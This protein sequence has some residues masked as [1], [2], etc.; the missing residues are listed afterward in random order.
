MKCDMKCSECDMKCI[1]CDL[2]ACKYIE[3]DGVGAAVC[4][5]HYG[6]VGLEENTLLWAGI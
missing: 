6:G 4:E 1:A 2:A 5:N 3:I